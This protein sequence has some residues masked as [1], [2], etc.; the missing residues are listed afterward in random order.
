MEH[1]P[2]VIPRNFLLNPEGLWFVIRTAVGAERQVHQRRDVR[3]VSR[4][5]RPV[6]MPVVQFG[7]SDEPFQGP[8]VEPDVR[9]NVNRPD[10]A[11]GDQAGEGFQWE[12]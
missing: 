5:P 1:L 6:M 9:V 7:R 10:S 12:S 3:I 4:I 11:E 2:E 8:D